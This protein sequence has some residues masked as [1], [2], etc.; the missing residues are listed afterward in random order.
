LPEFRGV[1]TIAVERCTD[2]VEGW[3]GARSLGV[4]LCPLHAPAP[5]LLEAWEALC[6]TVV[7]L[8]GHKTES[9]EL[10]RAT[11]RSARRDK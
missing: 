2:C 11:I 5:R 3:D 10:A 1:V 9:F 4:A 6:E 8:G 7:T